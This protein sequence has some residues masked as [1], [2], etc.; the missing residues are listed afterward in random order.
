MAIQFLRGTSSTLASSNQVFLAGQPVFESD[1]GQIKIGNGVDLFRNLPY[2]GNSSS[3]SYEDVG[4]IGTQYQDSFGGV[5]AIGSNLKLATFQIEFNDDSGAP[6]EIKEFN[7]SKFSQLFA[8]RMLAYWA[9]S[10][11]SNDSNK[12]YAANC[13]FDLSS[14][15]LTCWVVPSSNIS[16]FAVYPGDFTVRCY[17]LTADLTT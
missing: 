12:Y 7:L 17:V 13:I 3:I 8:S 2:V 6:S 15:V 10:N 9:S 16:T 14:K 1:T 4:R 5:Y 11:Y